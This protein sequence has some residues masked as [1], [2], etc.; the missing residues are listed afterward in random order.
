MLYALNPRSNAAERANLNGA[1]FSKRGK[2][3]VEPIAGSRFLQEGG[4]ARH[5]GHILHDVM[6]ETKE[7]Y[8]RGNYASV[9]AQF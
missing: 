1:V 8:R 6:Q 5:I 7:Q 9:Q 2:N 4:A 3:P